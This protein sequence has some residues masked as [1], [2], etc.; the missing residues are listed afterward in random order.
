VSRALIVR[1]RLDTVQTMTLFTL[2]PAPFAGL[3]AF[4]TDF[5]WQALDAH[6]HY[7]DIGAGPRR[8]HA[9]SGRGQAVTD[10]G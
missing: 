2:L 1:S 10:A 7:S 4:K 5:T 6:D 8:W 3:Y 9:E